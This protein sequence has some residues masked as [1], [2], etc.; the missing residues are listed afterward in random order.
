MRCAT[1]TRRRPPG[2]AMPSRSRRWASAARPP[3]PT[4]APFRSGQLQRKPGSTRKAGLAPW[5][6]TTSFLRGRRNLL[7]PVAVVV[8]RHDPIAR[9]GPQVELLAHLADVRIDGAGGEVAG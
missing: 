4:G 7:E 8:N 9:L 3:R 1:A 6:K 2:S 5:S